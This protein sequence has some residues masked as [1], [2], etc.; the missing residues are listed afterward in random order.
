MNF[1]K[2]K[3]IILRINNFIRILTKYQNYSFEI[4]R[5]ITRDRIIGFF[6]ELHPANFGF[7]L[8]RIGN[9]YDGGYLIPNDLV[10]VNKCIS[11]GVGK[12]INF[13]KFLVTKYGIKS[14][15]A[16]PT[17]NISEPLPSAIKFHQIAIG[18]SSETNQI[19]DME[20]G[21]RSD[22]NSVTLERFINENTDSEEFDL[23]LQM[24]IENTEYLALLV[25][26]PKILEKFRVMIIEFHSIPSIFEEK[27]FIEII[28]PLF[29]KINQIFYVA[30]IHANNV[31]KP[32]KIL[33]FKIPHGLEV[34]FHNRNRIKN[35]QGSY[36][37]ET[38]N[39]L[40][41][42]CDPSKPEVY[43]DRKL[44]QKTH[45]MIDRYS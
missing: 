1:F 36:I 14:F 29:N 5:S 40:D 37:E 10:G 15:L 33:N 25:S 4:R 2:N 13:E 11:P 20:S 27:Y 12:S 6:N 44:F 19:I 18:H 30:H 22:F 31:A 26:E 34:T 35:R 7:E 9:D 24:D 45:K 32:V 16:D 41:K 43:L 28:K 38:Y 21:K 39:I 17:V 42:P 3:K 8:I 23:L